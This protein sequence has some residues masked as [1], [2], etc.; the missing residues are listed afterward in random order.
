VISNPSFSTADWIEITTPSTV[1]GA[2]VDAGVYKD[3][4]FGRNLQEV[5]AAQFEV[6]WWYRTEFDLEEEALSRTLLLDFDGINYS[7]DIWLNG[8]QVASSSEVFGI[9][10]RFQFDVSDYVH[11]GKNV[12][13]ILVYPPRDGYLYTGF[14]DWNP[15]PPDRNMGIF[16]PVVLRSVG[17]VSIE[18]PCVDTLVDVIGE[19]SADLTV[20]AILRNHSSEDVSGTLRASADSTEVASQV[21]LLAG[22]S[23]EINLSPTDF[24]ELHW[25]SP[26]LWWPSNLGEPYLY[27]LRV[28]F[29]VDGAISDQAV[30]HFGIRKVEDYI[31]PGGHRGF[32]ING[33]EVLIK[34]AG[35]TDDL[36]LR[37]TLES[38]KVQIQYVKHSNLNSIRLEGIW[39][40]DHALY[41]LCDRYGILLMVGWSCHWE[42]E[43]YLGKPVDERFGGITAEAD[44]DLV[45]KYF[46]D[47][48]LWLRNHP[49]I[50]VWT[51]ASDKVPHPD[52]ELKYLQTL[53]QHDPT[54]PYLSS[55]GGI[56]S[57][58]G[59]ITDSLI[60]SDI[61]GSSRMKM[62]GPYAYTPPVYWFED[63]EL[64]GAYGFNTETGPGAQPPHLD[65][66]RRMLPEE[67]HWPIDEV[68]NFHCAMKEFSDLDRFTTAMKHRLGEPVSLEDFSRK[69]QLMNYE[70]MRPMFEAFQ[71]NKGSATGVVHWMLN[72]AWPKMYWQ[73]Y[74]HDL[75]PNAA[76]YSARN[77]CQPLH[78]LYDYSQCAVYLINDLL[79]PVDK[80]LASVRVFDIGSREIFSEQFS[81]SAA[82]ESS[83][84]I[85]DLEQLKDMS[86]TYFLDLRLFDR[87]GSR[88]DSSLYWLS[89]KPDILDYENRIE[90]WAFYTPTRSYADFRLLNQLPEVSVE[91]VSI[92]R[93]TEE[94]IEFQAELRNPSSSI[95]FF[96]EMNLRSRESGRLVIPAFW[97]DN[98]VSLVPGEARTVRGR[99]V[100]QEPDELLF[101]IN[102]WNTQVWDF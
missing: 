84:K 63:R 49:S 76:F 61:S 27:N 11:S 56:G 86:D 64:G 9:Y 14:V 91:A 77:A 99:A 100:Y 19:L 37:D 87:E 31:N 51:V 6:P 12:L 45:D 58:K 96:L 80:L 93:A 41:D 47:Q 4:Y 16:R 35:W 28:E 57:E 74:G 2:L 95:A 13:A 33:H 59:I 72:S 101:E 48:V 102:G 54:R 10:R 94:G 18:S 78:L 38:L 69:A 15:P 8:K 75:V 52:L 7:A 98:Y 71:A 26:Q 40:K 1:L 68:W 34:S 65:S 62:L 24:P 81:V 89:T 82:A 29:E 92:V 70:L 32:R 5:P 66:I 44:I 25:S 22:Q 3:P 67:N 39:G 46:H 79:Q 23:L 90:P 60:I 20:K 30:T 42:H 73:L 88:V 97:D 50:F 17:P 36:L 53:K 21:R 43:D 55:T 83:S 85:L